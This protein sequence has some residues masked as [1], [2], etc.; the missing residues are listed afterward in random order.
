AILK[1]DPPELPE[2]IPALMRQI[3]ARCLEKDPAN[4]FQSAK[5]LGFALAQSSQAAAVATTATTATRR[6][7]TLAA[8]AGIIACLASGAS[9]TV[10]L[11]PARHAAP[12]LSTYKFTS[13]TRE[14]VEARFSQWSPD[15]TSIAYTARVHGIMQVFTRMLGDPSAV[16][17]TKAGQNCSA[18][19]WS[20]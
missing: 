15:G 20:R 14:D 19:F 3:V 9:L 12:D 18:P 11:G 8:G 5:D 10:L 1:Q 7:R 2:S 17:V 16:Q 4:R 6:K 13:I